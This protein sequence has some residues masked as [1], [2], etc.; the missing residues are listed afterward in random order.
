MVRYARAG[1]ESMA[2]AARIARAYTG[3][4]IIAFCG[5]HGWQD[6]YLGNQSQGPKGSQ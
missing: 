3:R 2:I 1:G 5:Y 4:D 6:W